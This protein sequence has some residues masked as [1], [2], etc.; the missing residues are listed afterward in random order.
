MNAPTYKPLTATP[1]KHNET[2]TE[3]L[4]ANSELAKYIRC[5]WGSEK[6]Y[7]QKEEHTVPGIVSPDTCVDIIYNIDH[8]DN[9]VSGGFCGIN[10]ASFCYSADRKCGHLISTFAIRFYAWGAYAFS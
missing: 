1:Y 4:P 3:M 7:L 5:F 6:P 2:Y 8:T 10:D 9:T